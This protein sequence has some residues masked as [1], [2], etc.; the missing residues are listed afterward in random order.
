MGRRGA[1]DERRAWYAGYRTRELYVEGTGPTLVLVHG[2]GHPAPCW[3]PVL[4]RCARAGH[5]AVAVDLPGFGAADPC[6]TGPQL[7]QLVSF[8]EAVVTTHGAVTPVVLVGNSLGSATSVRLLD[9]VPGLPV[10][11]LV[12]TDT[13]SDQWTPLS[14]ALARGNRSALAPLAGVWLPRSLARRGADATAARLLY[15][16]PRRADPAMVA[17]LADQLRS[18]RARRD[19]TRLA[20][21]WM[22]ELAVVGKACN[23]T[24]PAIFVHGA[25]DRLVTM[26]ASA[27]LHAATPGSRLVVL[28]GIGHCPHLD[29]PDRIAELAMDLAGTTGDNRIE[30]A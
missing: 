10:R 15:G 2:F 26:A 13:A 11:G 23:I 28:P 19:M 16:D 20:A 5:A 30:S 24:C 25:R 18:G 29:A 27:N 4:E 17:L 14:R 9:T 22:S 6:S 3:R 8:L 21:H 7:P 12:A 1:I